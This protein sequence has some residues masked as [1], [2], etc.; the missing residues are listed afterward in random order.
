MFDTSSGGQERQSI[1]KKN[2]TRKDRKRMIG[3]LLNGPLSSLKSIVHFYSNNSA[4]RRNRGL[5]FKTESR[6]A[7]HHLE[8]HFHTTSEIPESLRQDLSRLQVL[9]SNLPNVDLA[10]HIH[11]SR[12]LS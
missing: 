11:A 3:A 5:V 9:S 8:S 2:T 7:S 1:L 4:C 12:A 10:A 6:P